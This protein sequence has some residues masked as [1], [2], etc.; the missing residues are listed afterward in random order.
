[1]KFNEDARALRHVD[2]AKLK[3]MLDL[4]RNSSVLEGDDLRVY[5]HEENARKSYLRE[6]IYTGLA[7]I[8]SLATV[9]AGIASYTPDLVREYIPKGAENLATAGLLSVAGLS[10]ATI[11]AKALQSKKIAK[12]FKQE[13]RDA[14]Q[15]KAIL[16]ARELERRAA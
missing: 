15:N 5:L 16:R 6:A 14:L 1:M 13:S 11:V 9:A 12:S 10:G 7:A 2:K 8:G 3:R 4:R